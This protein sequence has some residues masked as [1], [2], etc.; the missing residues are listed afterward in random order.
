MSKRISLS[1]HRVVAEGKLYHIVPSQGYCG[2]LSGLIEV[3]AIGAKE[4]FINDKYIHTD[5]E[6]FLEVDYSPED[7][8]AEGYNWVVYKYRDDEHN[9][10]VLPI[11]LFVQHT[12]EY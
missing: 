9:T 6:T 7:Y 12:V 8:I 4:D 2:I 11:E 5:I 10:Y 3:T 1:V